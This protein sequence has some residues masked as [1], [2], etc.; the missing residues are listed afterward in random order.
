MT[1]GS[2]LHMALTSAESLRTQCEQFGLD[3]EDKQAKSQFFQLAQ[4]IEQQVVP[5]LRQRVNQ[6]EQQ[7]PQ[8]KVKQEAY[9]QAGMT[10]STQQAQ[11][12][13]VNPQLGG[14]HAATSTTQ[15]GIGMATSSA[16]TTTAKP[17]SSSNIRHQS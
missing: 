3:T 1:V 13:S 5:V 7:E 14:I 10:N 12:A 15:S 6:V 8:Y 11:A 4:C 16:T 2:K 9:N 17:S